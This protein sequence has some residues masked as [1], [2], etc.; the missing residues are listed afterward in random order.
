M[1]EKIIHGGDIYRNRIQQDFSV[2]VNPLG[3]PPFVKEAIR[4]AADLCERYPDIRAEELR[5]A[6]GSVYGVPMEQILIG[7]GSSELL[8]AVVQALKPEK[9]VIP[10]PS[11][12]GYER[13]ALAAD[14]EIRYVP[15]AK[16]HHF[17]IEDAEDVSRLTRMLT[18]DVSLLFLANPN[19]PTGRC[20]PPELLEEVFTHCLENGIRVVLDECFL[21]FVEDGEKRSFLTRT[22]RWPNLIVLRAF[23]KIFAMPGVRLGYL[24]CADPEFRAQIERQLP[25]WNVSLP[26]QR[27][28]LAAMEVLRKTSYPEE[29]I[30]F[31]KEE[32]EYLAAGLLETNV[33]VFPSE[34]N[35]LLLYTEEPIYDRLLTKGILIRD[36]ANFRGLEKGYYRVAVR[37][38]EENDLLLQALDKILKETD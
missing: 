18:S 22:E 3:M 27:A 34:V 20:I 14:G 12:F 37:T 2:N 10:V 26:A 29:T 6:I 17:G 1:E 19:N 23:T 32:R 5:T 21:E 11:F 28:G 16:K 36:C 13:A 24:S 15:M 38:R 35:F 8:L 33:A 7:N 4:E 31:V 30:R 9:I 25:E